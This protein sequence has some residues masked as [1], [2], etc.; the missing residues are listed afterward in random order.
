MERREHFL[1]S[2]EVWWKK[3][4]Y[5][6]EECKYYFS[7]FCLIKAEDNYLR[8]IDPVCRGVCSNY[9]NKRVEETKKG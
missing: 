1:P 9:V 4:L 7:G 2:T 3:I 6:K 8:E 5:R